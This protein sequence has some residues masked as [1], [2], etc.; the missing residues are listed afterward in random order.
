MSGGGG[1]GTTV[2]D[3]LLNVTCMRRSDVISQVTIAKASG[4]R[5]SHP[6]S[7]PRHAAH[8]G[9]RVTTVPLGDSGASPRGGE[10]CGWAYIGGGE[11]GHMRDLLPI[12]LGPQGARSARSHRPAS[13][14][15]D[16]S[17]ATWR[18]ILQ[19]CQGI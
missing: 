12:Q 13:E 16:C 8:H 5:F 18:P 1:P 3:E 2:R 11:Q 14:G 6:L 19:R 7:L 10:V 9:T 15:G 4:P 17:R